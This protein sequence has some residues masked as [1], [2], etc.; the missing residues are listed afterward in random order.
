MC[1]YFIFL[2]V[3]CEC[4]EKITLDSISRGSGKD[5]SLAILECPQPSCQKRPLLEKTALIKNLLTKA[6]RIHIQKYYAGWIVCEDPGCSGRTR[7]CPLAFQRAFPVCN[8]CFKAIMY[9]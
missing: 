6:M 8:A 4:G 2:Q 7:R 5:M 1:F 9:R 3:T